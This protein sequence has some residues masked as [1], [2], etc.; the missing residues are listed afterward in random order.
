MQVPECVPIYEP[1]WL[2]VFAKFFCAY[3]T[4]VALALVYLTKTAS[5]THTEDL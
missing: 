2:I 1:T 3:M 4:L 5:K